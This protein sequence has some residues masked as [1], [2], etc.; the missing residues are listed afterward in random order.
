MMKI[1]YLMKIVRNRDCGI[2]SLS[3]LAL[4]E[5]SVV[6]KDHTVSRHDPDLVA[7][8]ERYGRA[9][10]GKFASLEII[11]IP[12]ESKWFLVDIDGSESPAQ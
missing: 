9:A 3:E 12:D 6:G 11:E 2:Y 7:I 1:L 4:S 8:V 5:L 10:G